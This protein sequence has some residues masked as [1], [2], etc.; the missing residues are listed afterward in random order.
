M[1]RAFIFEIFIWILLLLSPPLLHRYP[2]F[3]SFKYKPL[4][5]LATKLQSKQMCGPRTW[6]WRHERKKRQKGSM[7]ILNKSNH[8]TFGRSRKGAEGKAQLHNRATRK[9]A[10]VGI[11]KGKTAAAIRETKICVLPALSQFLGAFRR[12]NWKTGAKNLKKIKRI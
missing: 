5:S 9:W 2:H 7:K 12:L 8:T 6:Q 10:R 3:C 4:L 11:K 1:V